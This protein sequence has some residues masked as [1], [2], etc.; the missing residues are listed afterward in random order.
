MS[1]IRADLS[2]YYPIKALFESVL[3]K[4][5]F[6][7]VKDYGSLANWRKNYKRLLKAIN[8]SIDATVEVV[9]SE[10]RSDI[11]HLLER[12]EKLI[13]TVD[14]IDEL[15]AGM[16]A[17]LGE[18][19]FLQIGFVPRG[20]CKYKTISLTKSNWKLTPVRTVQYVQSQEQRLQQERLAERRSG[21]YKT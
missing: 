13:E 20:H 12:G 10:W 2:Q 18:L 19:A 17:I 14:T 7:C 1:D 16:V 9:D 11:A 8:V 15:H 21:R 6:S 4:S 3:G 5:A